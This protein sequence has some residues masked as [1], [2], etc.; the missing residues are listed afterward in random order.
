MTI[1]E[2]RCASTEC[3]EYREKLRE[4]LLEPHDDDSSVGGGEHDRCVYERLMEALSRHS[5]AATE[6][7]SRDSVN[8]SEASTGTDEKP[9][10]PI[11]EKP[12]SALE[13]PSDV[14]EPSSVG[15][16][17]PWVIDGPSPIVDEPSSIGERPPPIADES[18]T[19]EVGSILEPDTDDDGEREAVVPL[20]NSV[21][22]DGDSAGVNGTSPPPSKSSSGREKSLGTGDDVD[23]RITLPC[24]AGDEFGGCDD[25]RSLLGGAVVPPPVNGVGSDR[26]PRSRIQ[27]FD[28]FWHKNKKRNKKMEALHDST[29]SVAGRLTTTS[30]QNSKFKQNSKTGKLER[31]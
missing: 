25:S 11:V 15:E 19:D 24:Q 27:F 4:H 29:T 16:Q 3:I 6:M 13:P 18:L 8:R 21:L 10:S 31:I 5:V 22:Y 1:P 30:K 26:K 20:R 14:D 9:P 7:P 28:K 23:E 2:C 17:P 12:S